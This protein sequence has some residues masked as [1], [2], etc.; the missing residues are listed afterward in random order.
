[1]SRVKVKSAKQQIQDKGV[2]SMFNKMLGAEDADASIVL[3]KY[4]EISDNVSSFITI[5]TMAVERVLMKAFPEQESAC[6]EILEYARI[7]GAIEFIDVPCASDRTDVVD[8]EICKHYTDLK[9]DH[10]IKTMI[11]TCKNLIEYK[12]YLSSGD[13][14]DG[15]FIARI[16]GLSFTPFPFSRL[17]IKQLWASPCITAKIK[18][19]ILMVL[20]I[21]M[22]VSISIYKTLT[23][24]DIDVAEFSKAIIGSISKVKKMIPRCEKAFAKIEE[25]V[26]LLEGNFGGYYKD[27]I[28][29]QNPSTIIESFV[30]D[31]SSAGAADPQTTQ[32]FRKIIEYYRKAT[33]GKIKDPNIKKVFDMLN[34]NFS[35]MEK[36]DT[37][38]GSQEIAKDNTPTK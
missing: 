10:H 2:V 18:E 13:H 14:S 6:T 27:F 1:M 38:G 30:I 17:D 11:L 29:S 28:Q 25:S 8:K 16:P 12:Q 35:M 15:T 21:T 9:S 34:D 33:H 32:Q 3:P 22:D 37:G 7:L 20:K 31:V 4:K 19:Y 23:S 36:N 5:I 26:Q 24:P